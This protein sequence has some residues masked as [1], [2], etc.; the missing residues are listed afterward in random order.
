MR[1]G[2]QEHRI[3]E[4][5]PDVGELGLVLG[6]HDVAHRVLHPRVGRHDEQGRQHRGAGHQPDAGQVQL[7]REA[8]PAE[9]PDAQEGGLEEEGHQ[10]LHGERP[11]EDVAHEPRV[12]RPVH[13]E[14]ELLHQTGH[15]TDGHVDQQQGAEELGEPLEGRVVVLV[16]A[17]L[18]ESHQEGQAD[19]HRHEEEVVDA[20]GGE[21]P[22][23]QVGGHA[24]G[25]PSFMAIWWRAAV[26]WG[27]RCRVGPSG[28]RT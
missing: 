28:D 11:A 19:G 12:V 21:L 7:L 3:G 9:D 24:L 17:G 1:V 13:A 23:C 16:P 22:S 14:L 4:Q 20:G 8:V 6:V 10:T 26:G 2:P 18:E 25:L 27:V 5:G 15:D